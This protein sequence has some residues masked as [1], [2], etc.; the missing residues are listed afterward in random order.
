M[1]SNSV[2]L[3]FKVLKKVLKKVLN[4]KSGASAG[5]FC[6]NVVFYMNV[7]LCRLCS[8]FIVTNLSPPELK[9][10]VNV[11]FSR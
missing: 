8:G 7:M 6:N 3:G 11:I 2:C 10:T 1:C 5:Q 9:V 4:S